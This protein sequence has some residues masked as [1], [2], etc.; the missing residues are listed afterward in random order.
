MD[1]LWWKTLLKW[2]IWGY[3]YFRKHPY[4]WVIFWWYLL[5]LEDSLVL[6]IL[7][8]QDNNNQE[9]AGDFAWEHKSNGFECC[10]GTSKSSASFYLQKKPAMFWPHRLNQPCRP[11]WPSLASCNNAGSHR[12]VCRKRSC[13]KTC[14]PLTTPPSTKHRFSR[15]IS[16]EETWNTFDQLMLSMINQLS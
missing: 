16:I 14:Q 5:N 4:V 1:G 8:H 7:E 3:P 6:L 15:K 12:S 11:S 10:L 2:M 9:I 13:K